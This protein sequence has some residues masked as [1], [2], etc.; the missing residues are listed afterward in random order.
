MFLKILVMFTVSRF[1]IHSACIPVEKTFC[2][3]MADVM[4]PFPLKRSAT[5]WMPLCLWRN[6]A[7]VC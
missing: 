1:S 7:S 5:H 4:R 3:K 2:W 6:I